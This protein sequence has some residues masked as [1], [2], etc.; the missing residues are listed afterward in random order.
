[1][2]EVKLSAEMVRCSKC[3]NCFN[4]RFRLRMNDP[5]DEDCR[6]FCTS[7]Y[8]DRLRD[9]ETALCAK[10]EAIRHI[11]NYFF[12]K[13]SRTFET[14]AKDG[15]VEGERKRLPTSR[16]A[17][18]VGA[19]GARASR[20][21]QRGDP[22]LPRR[23]RRARS[24]SVRRTHGSAP[25]RGGCLSAADTTSHRESGTP[26]D[27]ANICPRVALCLSLATDY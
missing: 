1:M 6:Y 16:A 18:R 10:M 9:K 19:A 11:G 14:I 23:K 24:P 8:V 2:G 3:V 13:H 26:A 17:R 7:C 5:K 22:Q 12:F 25:G 27:E 21:A 4:N 15:W 20:R